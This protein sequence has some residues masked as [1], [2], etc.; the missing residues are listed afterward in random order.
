MKHQLQKKILSLIFDTV[1][2][3]LLLRDALALALCTPSRYP[4]LLPCFGLVMHNKADQFFGT[5]TCQFD[6]RPSA[7]TARLDVTASRLP[8]AATSK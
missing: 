2:F 8:R 1:A 3:L 7:A 4:Q 6:P 5:L